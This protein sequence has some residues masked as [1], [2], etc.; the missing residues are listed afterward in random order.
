MEIRKLGGN[1]LQRY[2]S[3]HVRQLTGLERAA[4]EAAKDELARAR[5]AL[6]RGDLTEAAAALERAS[7]FDPSNPDI[8]ELRERV[9][10]AQPDGG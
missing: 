1:V 5:S 6:E 3:K 8:A 9:V 4:E 7:T 10:A 2:C